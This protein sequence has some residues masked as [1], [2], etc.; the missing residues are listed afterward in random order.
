[1]K[2]RTF[3][4]KGGLGVGAIGLG[5]LT[6]YSCQDQD[7]PMFN[8]VL[9]KKDV[10]M[11][12]EIG[13]I[14]IPVTDTPGAKEAGV[15][16]FIA[17]VVQDCYTDEE[18]KRFKE[19]LA[20]IN[21]MSNQDFRHDFIDCKKDDRI[22]L[23][24]MLEAENEGFKSLKDLIVVSYLSSET[25]MTQFYQYHPVPGRFDECTTKVPW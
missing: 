14:I 18:K 7:S 21:E 1:M 22:D 20:T 16:E 12:N 19:T 5:L 3:I 9:S 10:K 17:V 2:R 15:G 8:E 25:G 6:N 23:V 13:D 24:S 4:I 11:I